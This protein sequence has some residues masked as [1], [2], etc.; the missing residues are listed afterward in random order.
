MNN[1]SPLSKTAYQNS[2][3]TE[4]IYARIQ[5]ATLDICY[6]TTSFSLLIN[7]LPQLN[8]E[9]TYVLCPDSPDLVIDAGI[10]ETY[11]WRN[12]SNDVV[13]TE[14]NFA[15]TD[16]GIYQL[17]VT[18]TT[19]GI[20]C[21][22]TTTFEV[23]SSGAPETISISSNG[24]SDIITLTIAATG[25]GTFEYS[26][27]G[28]NYQ[29]SNEFE[30]FPGEYTV[31]VRDPF[32]CRILTDTIFVMGYEKFFTPNG[33]NS[34]ENWNVIGATAFPN[35]TVT[36]YNRYGQLLKQMGAN[37]IGWDG[38]Y[39]GNPVPSTDYWFRFDTGEGQQMTGHFA[40]KR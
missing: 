6:D 3:Y 31:F 21:S 36:I 11:E 10:F 29:P 40:L 24:F 9:D 17:T 33:D 28:V 18:E 1:E 13:G 30:V 14:Q 20:E 15:V 5:H 27:D 37:S 4:T 39:L 34:H 2:L 25:I 32:A 22:N 26:I 35:A 23:V 12:E 19:N 7:P 16:L 8:L 38:T